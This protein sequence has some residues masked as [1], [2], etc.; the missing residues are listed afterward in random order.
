MHSLLKDD[1]HE[2]ACAIPTMQ[3]MEQIRAIG[4]KPQSVDLG[5]LYL[6]VLVCLRA[7]CLPRRMSARP[8]R[9]GSVGFAGEWTWR[10]TSQSD[11]T[12]ITELA[13]TD[14]DT[15]GPAARALPRI[16][17]RSMQSR[18]ARIPSPTMHG[19]GPATRTHRSITL[20]SICSDDEKHGSTTAAD[21]R[22]DTAD[23]ADAAP[24]QPLR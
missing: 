2:E 16:A 15:D 19:C 24:S 8:M 22:T 5:T 4:L 21:T 6:R 18:S 12:S 9:L 17:P 13:L 14:R 3:R 11:A 23:A 1:E 20:G 10:D 7:G